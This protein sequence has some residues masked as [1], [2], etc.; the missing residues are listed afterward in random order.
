[1][2][3]LS[4]GDSARRTKFRVSS[5]LDKRDAISIGSVKS[6]TIW[7]IHRTGGDARQP[8]VPFMETI[9]VAVVGITLLGL[10]LVRMALMLGSLSR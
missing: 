4:F 2:R 8:E 6:R 9:V 1:M 7:P 10:G 5:P 3:A